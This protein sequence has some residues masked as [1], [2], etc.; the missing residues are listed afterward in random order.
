M[1]YWVYKLLVEKL[2]Q[3]SRI[4]AAYRV[5]DNSIRLDF[6]KSGRYVFDLSTQNITHPTVD[7][8]KKKYSAPFDTVLSKTFSKSKILS[9]TLSEEDKIINIKTESEQGYKSFVNE[10]ILELTPKSKN[11]IIQN[12]EGIVISA[13]RYETLDSGRQ[14]RVGSRADKLPTAPFEFSVKPDEIVNIDA[15]IKGLQENSDI[16]K[17]NDLKTNKISS[18]KRKIANLQKEL[19]SLPSSNEL[20]NSAF[21]HSNAANFALM[22]MQNINIYN[23][24]FEFEN[25]GEFTKLDMPKSSKNSD[26]SEWFF[27]RAKKLKKKAKGI[28]LE[29]INLRDKIVFF[30]KL[31]GVIISSKS[32]SEIDFYLP[33]QSKNENQKSDGDIYEILSEGAKISIGKNSK[34]NE[35][36]LKL[37]RANDYWFHLKDLSSSHV[38]LNTGKNEPS[39]ALLEKTAKIC[40]EFSLAQKGFFEVDFAKRRDVSPKGGGKADYVNYKTLRVFLE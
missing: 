38:V 35:K 23:K 28:E 15:Y 4:L 27:Q 7:S 40:A 16:K 12:S 1:R 14:I 9:I 33:K 39:R 8:Y 18:I 34:G 22:N 17:L 26:V 37:A 24:Y 36:V 10:L 11:V 31:I 5:D 25:N 19:D 6:D 3:D 32:E 13:L 29:I 2:Q 20:Q 21:E 30:E